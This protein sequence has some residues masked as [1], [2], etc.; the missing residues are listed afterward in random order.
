VGLDRR[1]PRR[2]RQARSIAAPVVGPD[3]AIGYLLGFAPPEERSR[4][5]TSCAWGAEL[6]MRAGFGETSIAALS[7]IRTGSGRIC[8]WA[9]KLPRSPVGANSAHDAPSPAKLR[10]L[11]VRRTRGVR[12]NFDSCSVRDPDG[13]RTNLCVG[14]EAGSLPR[15]SEL[16]S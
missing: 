12:R 15:G 5:M 13:I 10:Q 1:G 3:P 2:F 9:M 7:G 14:D 6:R 11:G 16:G 4:L 8:A